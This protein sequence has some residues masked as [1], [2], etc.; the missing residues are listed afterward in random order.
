MT[1]IP[2]IEL[3][4]VEGPPGRAAILAEPHATSS[5]THSSAFGSVARGA[6]ALL[7]TQP[8]TWAAS[9]LSLAVVP[10]VLGPTVF[11]EV[12]LVGA[13]STLA[14]ACVCMGIPDFL[15]RQVASHP[16]SI[17]E[18]G[19]SALTLAVFSAMVLSIV[20][21]LLLPRLGLPVPRVLLLIA[22]AG[23][24]VGAAWRVLG[25]L[26]LGQERYSAYALLTAATSAISTFPAVCVLLL[27]HSVVA[28]ML[29]PLTVAVLV[30]LYGWMRFGIRPSRS[31]TSLG[32]WRW[33]ALAGLPF[34][35][36]TVTVTLYGSIDSVLL[37][38][39]SRAEVVGWYAAAYRVISIPVFIP[40]LIATPLFPTL[41]R[42]NRDQDT[43]RQ[44]T[45]RSLIAV[46]YATIP[47]CA[48]I[49]ALAPS[50][51]RL[52]HWAPGF[53][54]SVLLMQILALHEPL[55]GVDMVLVTAV[56]ASHREHR[57]LLV[58]ACLA[59]INPS[60][61]GFAVPLF[62]HF[63]HNG[64]IGAAIATVATEALAFLA[65]LR[66]L[67]PG[68]LHRRSLTVA[69][70]VALA[71]GPLFVVAEALRPYS[72]PA[73]GVAAGVSYIGA[74]FLLRIW[75]LA[76]LG[77]AW[78]LIQNTLQSRFRSLLASRQERASSV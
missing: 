62:E 2:E 47:L 31:A 67:P 17:H 16:E 63:A 71:S 56:L 72:L 54:H 45:N 28:F 39:L 77:M 78:R 14:T 49:I 21:L 57:W 55:V 36:A 74:G 3:P 48:M 41:S 22:L 12:A 46:M 29:V 38:F 1:T 8:V 35:A 59:L 50:I 25:G 53:E 68:T 30:S 27:S 42:L 73:A 65:A 75:T 15:Q 34:G 19:W 18:D 24:V 13:V 76:E 52:L 4:V 69:L 44:T 11:G 20:L 37:G 43:F 60:V 51:P 61:N 33:L 9:L 7:L 70:R 64:A 40:A 66:L 6:V 5:A 26:F 10:H 23:V 58:T 32:R